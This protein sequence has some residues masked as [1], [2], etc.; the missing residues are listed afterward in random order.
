MPNSKNRIKECLE[1]GAP[2]CSFNSSW[3]SGHNAVG[4]LLTLADLSDNQIENLR[5]LSNHQFLECLILHHNN[6]S[7]INGLHGLKYLQVLDLSFNNIAI[8]EGL[9]NLPI[10]EL[11][12]KGNN[13]K[14]LHGLD[15][16]P[17]LAH[18]DVSENAIV[19]LSQLALCTSLVHL[20]VSHNSV[21]YI[22]QVEYL[23]GIPWLTSLVLDN[24]PCEAKE[25]Y[26]LRVLFRLPKLLML[27][28]TEA[29]LEDKVKLRLFPPF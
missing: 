24:N 28:Q 8:I 25:L 7:S 18:L 16:L 17:H 20:N 11:R 27:D 3:N 14:Q 22:R 9:D 2:L 19:S 23:Q 6:L 29:L 15:K 21:E 26:R 13:I 10:K 1:F 12:L 4:S 5:D